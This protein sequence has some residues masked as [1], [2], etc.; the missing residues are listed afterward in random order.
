MWIMKRKI[1][2][3]LAS[4][5]GD[6]ISGE[7]IAEV[8]SMTRAN[9][10]KYIKELRK[11][12]F[13]IESATNKGYRLNR[14]AKSLNEDSLYYYFRDNSFVRESCFFEEID[15]TN[16]YLKSR[17]NELP[18][19]TLVVAKKQIKGRGRRTKEFESAPG[20]LYFSLLIQNGMDM[21]E[22]SFVTSIVAVAV[23]KAL[24]E[25]GVET[26][27]K[28]PNDIILKGRKLCGILTEMVSDMELNHRLIIG[29]GLNLKN[30]FSEELSKIAVSLEEEGYEVEAIPLLQKV[31]EYLEYFYE[32]LLRGERDEALCILRTE[33]YLIGKKIGFEYNHERKEGM[34]EDVEDDGSLR[35]LTLDKEVIR[36]GSG[37]VSILNIGQN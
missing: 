11:H 7:D 14:V 21:S 23:H 24:K 13:D 25:F 3:H 30:R 36:L 31:I 34:V 6:Y 33:S 37:E 4:K 28:W 16:N 22:V 2:D 12:G 5:Q 26:K 15:S 19:K 32:K 9:V 18:D 20:G 1:I 29:I 10:W 27:I 35:V 8:L 17:T